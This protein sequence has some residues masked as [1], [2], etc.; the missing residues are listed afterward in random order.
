MATNEPTTFDW[1]RI[2]LFTLL[3]ILQHLSE[4]DI[5]NFIT[6]FPAA[7][8][9]YSRIQ[10]CP[11]QRFIFNSDKDDLQILRTHKKLRKIFICLRCINF[12]ELPHV[13][14]N[15]AQQRYINELRILDS[16]QLTRQIARMCFSETYEYLT[17]LTVETGIQFAQQHNIKILVEKCPN[18]KELTYSFG[19][20]EPDTLEMLQPLRVLMLRNV[21]VPFKQLGQYLQKAKDTLEVLQYTTNTN[22]CSASAC[23]IQVLVIIKTLPKLKKLKELTVSTFGIPH[24]LNLKSGHAL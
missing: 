16:F 7:G 17:V 3:E 20:L 15:L 4:E 11:N 19:N 12:F 8:E 23:T 14:Q 5:D 18:L 6:A 10:A 22:A 21:Y 1:N 24:K 13:L 9:V 2:P